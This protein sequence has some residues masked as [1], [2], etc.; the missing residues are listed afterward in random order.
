MCK[1]YVKKIKWTQRWGEKS[2]S[3]GN[4]QFPT[5]YPIDVL[6]LLYI[7]LLISMIINLGYKNC[8]IFFSVRLIGHVKNIKDYRNNLKKY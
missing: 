7:N 8:R 5:V 4:G 2:L 1:M 3:L 6:V